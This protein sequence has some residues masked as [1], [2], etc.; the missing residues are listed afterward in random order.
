MPDS[1]PNIL[2]LMTDQQRGD[3]L[4]IED[5]PVLQTP[6]LDWIGASG[7]HFTRAYSAC[8]VCVPARRTMMTGQKPATHGALMNSCDPLPLD[9]PTLATE[10]RNAGYQTHLC[11][12]KHLQPARRRHGFDEMDFSDSSTARRDDDYQRYLASHGID[13]PKASSAHGAGAND[14]MVRPWHLDEQ[15]HFTNWVVNCGLDFLSRRDPAC[16]FFLKV[17]TILPHQPNTPPQVYYDRYLNMDLPKPYVGDWARVFDEP[18]RG[19]NPMNTWRISVD[20]Q[21]MHQMRAAYYGSINHISDQYARLL[22][23]LPPNTIVLFTSDHGEMLGD[24]Q[25]LRKRSSFE[26]SA[27]IP[28]LMKFPDEMGISQERK[29]DQLVE[30]MDVMPTLLDAAG[31][32]IPDTVDGESLMPLLRGETETWRTHL[33]G[34]CCEVPTAGSGMQYIVEG[35]HK[36]TWWPGTGDEH[37]F[38]LEADPHEMHNLADDDHAAELQ[39]FRALLMNELKGRPEGFTDGKTLRVLGDCTQSYIGPTVQLDV[40][41]H[42]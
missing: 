21:V 29:I 36:Y 5:H 4:G 2:L 12:K 10:L 40:A 1:R 8:P 38:D 16:P 9:T 15:F 6:H 7:F 3:A 11:G 32:D 27:R 28:F 25:W 34:E 22:M 30:L 13:I 42:G 35:K 37:L 17:S 23:T 19:L 20:D 26:P 41:E 31:V 14:W 24:H 39:H 18:Q 33:H